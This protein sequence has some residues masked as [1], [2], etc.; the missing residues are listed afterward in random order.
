MTTTA[1]DAPSAIP[2]LAPPVPGAAHPRDERIDF[3]RGIAMT[4]VVVNHTMLASWLQLLTVERFGPVTGAEAFVL[5]S[6][7]V[8]GIV[9]RTRLARGGLRGAQ[10]QMLRRA[11]KL[12]V[13]SVV[14]IAAVYLAALLP[15]VDA[16]R[17]TTYSDG[18]ARYDLYGHDGAW[19]FVA[20]VL[21]LDLGPSQFNVMGLYVA[22]LVIAPAVLW[23]L[24]RGWTAPVLAASV[25]L[26]ALHQA[27]E[28]VVLPAQSENAFPLLAWQLLFFGGM[29][30]GF[31]R[32]VVW[33]WLSR[34]R[35]PL[36]R[37]LALG[38]VAALFFTANL[39][40]GGV[41]GRG[42]VEL[43]P[44]PFV[45]SVYAAL[46]DR[47]AL[48]LGRLVV[49]LLL[50]AGVY[51]LLRAAPVVMRVGGW[52]FVPIGAASLYVFIVHVPLVLLIANLP[53]FGA[54]GQGLWLNAL[55]QIGACGLMWAL[56]R[57][58][59]LFRFIPR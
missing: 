21:L 30:A 41:P 26:W 49:L 59:V 57:R 3:L 40:A 15:G 34:H 37:A 53:G 54:S 12:Y 48:G 44:A 4:F 55:V 46:F 43:L 14:V 20:R 2:R 1:V 19:D 35:R 32:D 38:L 56:V 7:F 24:E 5:L 29:T 23:A 6:G 11:R 17:L 31:H 10:A 16:G 50:L 13:V 28:P 36:A 45:D 52:Y 39:R 18:G 25:A 8:L 58:R 22:L 51:L 47:T 27:L 9:S 33:R 42:R